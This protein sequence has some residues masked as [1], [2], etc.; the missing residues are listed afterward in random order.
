MILDRFG[1]P[2]AIPRKSCGF[3]QKDLEPEMP[4]PNAV[5]EALA[6]I[7]VPLNILED[8]DDE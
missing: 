5:M 2:A 3:V 8:A 4:S 1:R 6:A 7:G